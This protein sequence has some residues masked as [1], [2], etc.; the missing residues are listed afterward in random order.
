MTL[1]LIDIV[2]SFGVP[3]EPWVEGRTIPWDDPDFSRRM[4]SHHLSQAH[5]AAS[6]RLETIDRHV[7]FI[8]KDVLPVRP[9]RVLDLGCGPGLYSLRLA[10]AG[11][12]CVAVDF[13]PAAIEYAREQAV[14]LEAKL[15]YVLGDMRD[16][17]LGAGFDLIMLLF[18]ELNLFPRAE[19]IEML[20]R[21]RSLLAPA[22]LLLLEVHSYDFVL[23][24]GHEAP[25]WSAYESG[26]FSTRRHLRLDQSF[27]LPETE[28]ATGRHWIVDAE[29]GDVA[30]HGWTMKAYDDAGYEVLLR[31]AGLEIKARFGDLTGAMQP[32]DFPVI[33]AA[34]TH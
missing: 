19:V 7:E 29:T 27:W 23:A 25:K 2:R 8:E 14:G 21:W 22:G 26:L 18:G 30:R 24:R 13:A 1:H 5:D 16:A 6:R 33:V 15:R 20:A 28:H 4:L 11:H 12:E 34:S 32:S 17:D 3:P 31:Q 9:A 10:R